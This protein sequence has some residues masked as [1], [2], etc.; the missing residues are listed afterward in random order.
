MS[1]RHSILAVA[2]SAVVSGL[3]VVPGDVQAQ[4]FSD[5]ARERREAR[6]KRRNAGKQEQQQQENR[7]PQ[8]TREEP[9]LKVTPKLAKQVD[10]LFKAYEADDAAGV[11]AAAEP[12]M[13]NDAANAYDRA[14]A[15]R[16]VAAT[17]LNSDN[18]KAKDYLQKAIQ[19]DG[20]SNN[21]H[22]ESMLLLAQLQLQDDQFTEGLA[23]LERYLS[24]TK[25]TRTEDIALKG[26]ALY[27]AERYP[28]A[29]A[30]LKP[31]ID[32]SA[33]PK[34]EWVQMLM[35]TYIQ[36]DRT[37]EAS[38]LAESL[39]A[40]SPDDKQL[41]LNLA[42]MYLQ[43]D[44]TDKAIGML[45]RLRASGQLTDERDYRNLYALYLNS[46][47]KEKQAITI[48]NEGLEK[49]V[50][51]GTHQD[52]NALAQAY[53]FSDQGAQAVEAYKKAA[54]LAPDGESYLNLARALNNLERTAEAKEAAQ[55][56][57]NKGIKNPQ[58]AK[59]ILGTK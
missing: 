28:E 56:A 14:I 43:A 41:Q 24:E 12:L 42:A 3:A 5:S 39:L 19:F 58:D 59:R 7:F 8:A 27:L 29:A 54:P 26:Q 10:K 32:G 37:T 50:L 6:E 47:G 36:T 2:L 31:L 1:I 9:G 55:Q 38:A 44:Q 33:E 57:L 18:A 53:W 22:Y 16:L 45:E 11:L 23:T 17:Q 15:A 51:K 20:L 4:A 25:S 48:I 40:K 35:N 13:A 46:E 30:V 34:K 49:G 52:Y 21:E